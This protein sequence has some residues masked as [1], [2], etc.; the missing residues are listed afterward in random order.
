MF[1][2]VGVE[3]EFMPQS[4]SVNSRWQISLGAL[5]L[6]PT[7][8][9]ALLGLSRSLGVHG[10]GFG[11][12]VVAA[13]WICISWTGHRAF[14]PISAKPLN[15]VET[16]T[17]FA[18]CMILHGLCVPSV[19]TQPRQRIAVPPAIVPAPA[20]TPATA[21]GISL[22]NLPSNVHVDEGTKP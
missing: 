1:G 19:S 12:Y 17:L 11:L 6:L 4:V 2:D 10:F 14:L 8:L 7:S 18:L 22:L 3:G 20:K 9:A 13:C 5:L 16:C 21:S 15:L